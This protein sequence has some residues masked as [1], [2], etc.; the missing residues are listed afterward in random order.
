MKNLILSTIL[1]FC[2]ILS[3]A[4][5]HSKDIN[6]PKTILQLIYQSEPIFCEFYLLDNS[7]YI[8][9]VFIDE[10]SSWGD[11]KIVNLKKFANNWNEIDNNIVEFGRF[12]ENIEITEINS[13]IYLYLDYYIQG[14]SSGNANIAFLLY[15]LKT[16][17]THDLLFS[18]Y[19]KKVNNEYRVDG[20]F[21]ELNNKK[22]NNDILA[23]FEKKA[24][25]NSHIYIKNENDLNVNHPI[26]A[27]KKFNILN[28][29]LQ[30]YLDNNPKINRK[31]IV[32]YY[33]SSNYFKNIINDKENYTLGSIAYEVH[34]S[35]YSI[36]SFFKNYVLAHNKDSDVYFVVW[37]PK[38]QY[39]WIN[40]M[41]LD[42]KNVLKLYQREENYN[43][44]EIDLDNLLISSKQK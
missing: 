26:N 11:A 21:E 29:E 1:F 31:L 28:N 25:Q 7:E 38:S 33:K 6:D 39:D 2:Y 9:G 40:Y 5:T 30:Y 20:S 32:H 14:G 43:Y 19:L 12:A 24:I 22:Y 16:F 23:F 36:Y 18:G 37:V 13:N 17:E 34:N 8:L 3:Y 27:D 41:D 10:T 44:I 35:K 4:N 15:N 42:F